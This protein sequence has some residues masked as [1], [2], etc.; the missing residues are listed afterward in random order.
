MN[1]SAAISWLVRPRAMERTTSSSRSVSGFV[2]PTLPSLVGLFVLLPSTWLP[3]W[4]VLGLSLVAVAAALVG[5]AGHFAVVPGLFLL[6]SALTR[7]GMADRC[8]RPGSVP[9]VSALAF[10][11]TA[12][13]VL[14][15]QSESGDPRAMTAAGLMFAG[16]YIS[17][18]LSLLQTP[19][20]PMLRIL[21]EHLG[22]MALTN[23]LSATILVLAFVRITGD[24]P[25]TWTSDTVLLIALAV[26]TVQWGFS[27]LWLRRF[28]CGP[29]ERLWRWAT[30]GRRPGA[31]RTFEN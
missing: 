30:R 12:V 19:A 28:G 13:P 27:T 15:W 10:A 16:C 1:S 2:K 11:V 23:Y 4:A 24:S 22:R 8:E 25:R 31:P 7:Y 21:F 3:R 17:V 29:I 20:R 26:L 14:W 5:N 18:L 6:G 9:L